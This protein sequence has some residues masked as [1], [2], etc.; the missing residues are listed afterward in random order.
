[1]YKYLIHCFIIFYPRLNNTSCVLENIIR[2]LPLR[3]E[4][5]AELLLQLQLIGSFLT[6][7]ISDTFN[8]PCLDFDGLL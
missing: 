6:E 3:T 7:I 4:S 8:V 5:F 2:L 1:M